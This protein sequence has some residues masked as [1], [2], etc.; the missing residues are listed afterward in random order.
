MS[1][2]STWPAPSL[3]V[4][5]AGAAR[6]ASG[7]PGERPALREKLTPLQRRVGEPWTRIR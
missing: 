3:M 4:T 6:R 7:S 5:G 2:S 1:A